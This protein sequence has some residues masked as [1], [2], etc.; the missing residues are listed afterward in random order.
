MPKIGD[1]F[2][3][4][5]VG[6]QFLLWNVGSQLAQAVM[7][8]FLQAIQ[9]RTW[10]ADPNVPLSP[11]EAA[12][13]AQR[14][15]LTPDQGADEA[16]ASGTN[17]QRFDSMLH[18]AGRPPDLGSLLEMARRGIIADDADTDGLPSLIAALI[19]A[20]IRPQWVNAVG[21]LRTQIPSVAEVMNA[22]LEGQIEEPEA[23]RRY[24]LA[25]G[26]PTWFQTSYNAN[27][28]APTPDMLGVLANRGI[29]D[30]DGTGP[31]S[32]SFHQ[33]I[34][35]GPT[36]NKWFPHLRK[37]MEY[38]VP[39]RSVTAMVRNG[40]YTDAE[41]L[42]RYREYGMTASDAAAMLKDAHHTAAA[43]TK[44][45]TMSQ[46]SQLYKDGKIDRPKAL[47]LIQSLG[48]SAANAELILSLSD[49][50]KA[51]THVTAAINKVRALYTTHKINQAAA[52][53]SLIDLKVSLAQA[54]EL[55]DLWDLELAVNIRQL[56]PAQIAA[57]WANGVMTQAEAM[58]ELQ[59]LGYP[60]FDAWVIL[61]NAN[62]APLPGKPAIGGG[63]GVNP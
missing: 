19:D 63:V 62:K 23:H 58:T 30:W 40:S 22:W 11:A 13:L 59:H 18:A 46:V 15:V 10:K 26:D 36:R 51:D 16:A 35:E 60:E 45:L 7:A 32:T 12:D 2:K 9:N 56:T 14:G 3:S 44:D 49:V 17:R 28:T 29:I 21:Q 24:L 25:G 50:V 55:M 37:M 42:Q 1:L 48:Y 54:T 39:P 38:R 52:K 34:L 5:S 4:G 41:A 8:P 43:A 33:G 31:D 6:E 27:G 20:G 57:A 53:Q 61:S 47:T